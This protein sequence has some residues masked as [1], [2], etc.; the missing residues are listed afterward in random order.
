[1]SIKPRYI[2]PV[3]KMLNMKKQQKKQMRNDYTF[4]WMICTEEITSINYLNAPENQISYDLC[5][6]G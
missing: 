1:M 4:N 2:L 5:G 3:L 6:N